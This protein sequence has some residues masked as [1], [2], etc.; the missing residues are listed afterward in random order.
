MNKRHFSK[1][2]ILLRNRFELG[3]GPVTPLWVTQYNTL[4]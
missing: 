1:L 3:Q 4:R 2:V